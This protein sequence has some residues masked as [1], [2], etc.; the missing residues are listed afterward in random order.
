MPTHKK[1]S[2]RTLFYP[3]LQPYFCYMVPIVDTRV[4]YCLYYLDFE[5]TDDYCTVHASRVFFCFLYLSHV[6]HVT[7]VCLSSCH[8]PHSQVDSIPGRRRRSVQPMQSPDITRTRAYAA[9]GE[10]LPDQ[11]LADAFQSRRDVLRGHLPGYAQPPYG[12]K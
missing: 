6:S 5:S 12:G 2:K 11:F 4:K 1:Q 3:I 7:R 9:P 10:H 8:V